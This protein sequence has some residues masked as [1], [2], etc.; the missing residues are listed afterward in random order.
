M[1]RNIL[2][3]GRAVCGFKA[4]RQ[5]AWTM[6]LSPSGLRNAELYGLHSHGLR[7]IHVWASAPPN[8]E[9]I[10]MGKKQGQPER[11]N[12]G[13]Y[14]RL[15]LKLLTE[16]QANLVSN[17]RGALK[18]THRV[19]VLRMVA[20]SG[21]FQVLNFRFTLAAC[22][23]SYRLQTW[24]DSRKHDLLAPNPGSLPEMLAGILGTI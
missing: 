12:G 18:C 2:M 6:Q 5:R 3:S 13:L 14:S 7:A 8:L 23:T 19:T 22:T 11:G 10:L 21:S 15:P 9:N 20:A 24:F 16:A 4:R 17:L 1:E